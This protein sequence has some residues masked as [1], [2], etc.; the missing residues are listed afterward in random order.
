MNL[1]YLIQ[2]DPTDEKIERERQRERAQDP[3]N[4]CMFF[5]GWQFRVGI[6]PGFSRFPG[7]HGPLCPLM[8]V[9]LAKRICKPL[10]WITILGILMGEGTHALV[11]RLTG[12]TLLLRSRVPCR[13]CSDFEA[14]ELDGAVVHLSH[15]V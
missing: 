7:Q 12:R 15:V 8:A 4:N 1:V 3:T 6:Q 11:L 13:G 2:H 14:L 10:K 9:E 5:L